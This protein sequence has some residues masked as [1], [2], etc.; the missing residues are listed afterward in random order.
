MKKVFLP[1]LFLV[2][3][4][5][6]LYAT[7]NRAGEI[8]LTQV[9]E[10]T[11][12]INI[13]TFTYTL[14]QAD[15]NR[16]EVRWGDNTF[17]YANRVSI[18]KL[19][20]FYQKNIYITQ[21][22]FPGPGLYEIVVQDPNRNQGVKNI[23]NSVNVVFSIKTTILINSTLGDNSTP[24]L[25]NYPIDRAALNQIFIHNPAAYDPDGD[26]ISYKLTVCTEQDGR[27]IDGYTLPPA[28]DTLFVN[29]VTGDLTWITPVDTGIYNIAMDVEEWRDGVK[30]GNI[31][32]DM[33]IEVYNTD[34]HQPQQNELGNYCVAAG[35]TIA[36]DVIATDPDNDS[37]LQN[38]TG[39]PFVV[40]E[41]PATYTVDAASAKIGYSQ[42]RFE[43]QTR[44]SHVRDQYYT[45]IFKAEDSNPEITLVDIR[46][47]NIKVIGPAPEMPKLIPGSSSVTVTWRADTCLPVRGYRIYRRIGPAGYI[48]DTC[49]TCIP[50]D[51][52]YKVTGHTE[53]RLD[54]ILVDDNDGKG[55]VQGNEYCYVIVSVY[56]DGSLSYPSSENC[57]PLIEG[58]PSI[59]EVSVIEH[60]ASG[61]I[62]LAW[63]RPDEPDTIPG[64]GPYEYIIYRSD[65]LLGQSLTQVGS[66]STP[67]LSDTVWLD[68]NVDTRQFP[69][70]YSVELYN[71]APGNRMLLGEPENAS[72]LYPELTGKDNLVEIR[73]KKNVPWINYDYT[74]Y[75]LNNSTLEYDSIGFTTD[76][77]FVDDGLTNGVEYC[78]RVTSTGWR[79]LDGKLYENVNNSHTNCTV[80]VDSIPPCPPDLSGYSECDSGYNH[81]S[82]KYDDFNIPCAL[83]VVGYRLYYSPTLDA[84]PVLIAEFGDRYDT[85]YNHFPEQ[86]LTACYFVTAIDSFDNESPPSVLLCLDECTNYILPNVF[87]PNGD[88]IND[89]YR[90][91]RTSYVERV[92]MKIYNR[93]GILVFETEDPDINW[94]GKIS[95]SDR[96][97]APGVYYYVCDVYEYRLTGIEVYALT[98]FI[99]VYSG[100]DND[101]FIE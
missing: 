47:V 64:A 5:Y 36:F 57:T 96:L 68:E 27:P 29:P 58:T 14:S 55:L 75:R 10:L 21:H 60:S 15:R 91:L 73:M 72:S 11:Y 61:T 25:L 30:I 84:P 97:V 53:S 12:E 22:S 52:V 13:T 9:D 20:N 46:N 98:G 101:V 62:R 26:S 19:P 86:S 80:P 100:E 88:G 78:Y 48:P 16:L 70:S 43:W 32:R 17:S 38:A 8:T 65:D 3:L 45:A 50:P 67:D 63:A 24:V 85:V 95:S 49:T 33:Q 92:D 6:P 37:V 51:S 66:L 69:W 82:W 59:L 23:P 79:I 89:I 94:D 34:N 35:T 83:D 76:E 74:I 99:Y 77:V 1:I 56:P 7:H 44:C 93:W 71:D 18:T 42:A 31:V 87:S 41:S 4:V 54:T 28:N 2:Y 40:E 90:P 81:L 39:G